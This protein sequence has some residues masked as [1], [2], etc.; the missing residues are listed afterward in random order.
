MLT[1]RGVRFELW[2]AATAGAPRPRAPDR[3]ARPDGPGPPAGDRHYD[4]L[5][6]YRERGIDGVALPSLDLGRGLDEG[7]SV[8][9]VEAMAHGIPVIGTR[10]G[11]L[12][13]PLEGGAGLLVDAGDPVGLAAGL[14][15]L[16]CSADLRARLGA[17][18]RE[19]VERIMSRP[20]PASWCGGSM[21]ASR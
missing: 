12:P 13:E 6:L 14:A 4:L 5:R 21:P 3:P 18:G 7:L 15:E 20:S 8:G 19:R 17:A 16:L 9:L 2:I 1:S 11:G 10:T